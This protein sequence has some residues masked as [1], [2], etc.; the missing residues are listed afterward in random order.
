MT[1]RH[2]QTSGSIRTAGTGTT[3]DCGPRSTARVLKVGRDDGKRDIQRTAGSGRER[4]G[5]FRAKVEGSR[6]SSS[7]RTTSSD[8]RGL[9]NGPRD[10]A[11]LVTV[12]KIAS[13][14]LVRNSTAYLLRTS[15]ACSRIAVRT[16]VTT[17]T[18]TDPGGRYSRTG[19]P[20]WVLDVEAFLGPGMRDTWV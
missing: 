3:L 7:T 6:P 5:S 8:P 2:G 13:A 18:F 4:T 16:R 14:L 19:L 11:E 12:I 17:R 15:T 9:T 10:A 20:P 1:Q